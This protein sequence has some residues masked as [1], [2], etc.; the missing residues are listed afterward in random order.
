MPEPAGH[1]PGF[2]CV[3]R[4]TTSWVGGGRGPMLPV[5]D[6]RRARTGR[7]RGVCGPSRPERPGPGGWSNGELLA[8]LPFA[9]GRGDP[10]GPR[11]MR[12]F[13]QSGRWNLARGLAPWREDGVGRAERCGH[14]EGAS[15]ARG[16]DQRAV[17][18]E[19]GFVAIRVVS[20]Q[21]A[22][23]TAVDDGSSRSG[24]KTSPERQR[25]CS[26]SASSRAMATTALFLPFLPP[27]SSGFKPSASDRSPDLAAAGVAA[28]PSRARA[29]GTDL[30]PS[31]SVAAD[32]N[33]PMG[34]APRRA[35]GR[36][37]RHG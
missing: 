27:H 23:E 12:R 35:P 24:S 32:R 16:S 9:V 28:R 7:S 22:D 37:R 5:A 25:R 2:A 8:A 4:P 15:R 21:A 30:S 36:P 19:A 33:A 26:S 17:D 6:A 18:Y 20:D 31:R 13:D 3:R 10:R 1:G 29:A 34:L 14:L 11:C